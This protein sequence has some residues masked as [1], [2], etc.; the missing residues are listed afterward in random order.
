[1]DSIN[2][3]KPGETLTPEQKAKLAKDNMVA[4]ADAHKMAAEQRARDIAEG[5]GE[6]AVGAVANLLKKKL[7]NEEFQKNE[8]G[9]PAQ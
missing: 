5:R 7:E 4:S 3:I 2:E 8:R 6:P 1:M 9:I